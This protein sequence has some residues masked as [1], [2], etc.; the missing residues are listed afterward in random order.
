[1]G[2]FEDLTKQANSLSEEIKQKEEKNSNRISDYKSLKESIESWRFKNSFKKIEKEMGD[3]IANGNPDEISLL[4]KETDKIHAQI[5]A[6]DNDFNTIREL[7]LELKKKPDRHKCLE[8]TRATEAFLNTSEL[9]TLRNL[10]SFR[11]NNLRNIKKQIDDVLR[12]FEIEAE[13]VAQ[14]K[15]AAKDLLNS[16]EKYQFVDTIYL[17]KCV[18][19]SKILAKRVINTPNYDNPNDDELKL[20]TAKSNLD[21]CIKK[22]K[23]DCR[24]EKLERERLEAERKEKEEKVAKNKKTA[25]K[26]LKT[27]KEYESYED[28]FNLKQHLNDSEK[29]AKRVINTPNLDNPNDDELELQTAKSNLDQCIKKVEREM[30]EQERI[31]REKEEQER[32]ARERL[33]AEK[34]KKEENKEIIIYIISIA[35]AVCL[36]LWLLY[37]VA[38]F[39]IAFIVSNWWWILA[40]VLLILY[41]YFRATN[42]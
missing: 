14:N 21:Q 29:L 27:I 7:Y 35:A 31:K 3:F 15:E 13:K 25:S 42:D 8:V 4:Q 33:E 9:V 36:G 6:L 41:I 23:E 11:C 20:Q 16:S 37:I 2:N 38:K 22:Y 1:M 17:K 32:L 30:A 5:S 18:D 34:R 19:E 12:S 26:L 40:I 10:D 28:L 39:V 24:K